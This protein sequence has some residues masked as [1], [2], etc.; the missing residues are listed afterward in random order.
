[1]KSE[2]DWL[3]CWATLAIGWNMEPILAMNSQSDFITAW[4]SS[5]PLRTAMDATPV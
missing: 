5:I 4:F 1:M 3:P 2:S